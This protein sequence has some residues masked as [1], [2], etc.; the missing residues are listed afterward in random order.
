MRFTED[1]LRPIRACRFAAKLNFVIEENT[2][3]AMA[4][5]V[6]AVTKVSKERIRDELLKIL[7]SDTLRSP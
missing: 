6:E 2:F 1:G 4:E 3:M 7:E 5:T